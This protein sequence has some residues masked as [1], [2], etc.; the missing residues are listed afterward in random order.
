MNRK[1]LRR[2]IEAA[3]EHGWR[4]ACSD[5]M[6]QERDPEYPIGRGKAVSVD[7]LLGSLDPHDLLTLRNGGAR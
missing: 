3:Y 4:D 1:I 7:S 2:V 6:S 5:H